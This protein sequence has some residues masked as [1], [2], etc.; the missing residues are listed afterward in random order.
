MANYPFSQASLELPDRSSQVAVRSSVV[1]SSHS[2]LLCSDW[3]QVFVHTVTAA[4]LLAARLDFR[5]A[6][7]R[8]APWLPLSCP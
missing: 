4:P 5:P 8:I 2:Y 6:T 7:P 1:E 3:C